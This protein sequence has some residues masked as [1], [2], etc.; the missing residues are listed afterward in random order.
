MPYG[1]TGHV[2]SGVI[3]GDIPNPGSA[4][5]AE[6][7]RVVPVGEA[8]PGND[9]IV[10]WRLTCKAVD[11]ASV[12]FRASSL[13]ACIGQ[14]VHAGKELMPKWANGA[15]LLVPLSLGQVEG[16]G[17]KLNAHHLVSR[18]REYRNIVRVLRNVRVRG[19]RSFKRPQITL[20]QGPLEGPSIG[21]EEQFAV[22]GEGGRDSRSACG[23]APCTLDGAGPR[24][25]E[26]GAPMSR[27]AEWLNGPLPTEGSFGVGADL[28]GSPLRSEPSLSGW[29]RNPLRTRTGPGIEVH[30]AFAKP[31]AL[32]LVQIEGIGAFFGLC[33]RRAGGKTLGLSFQ[34]RCGGLDG[35]TAL[36]VRDIAPG[37]A[38]DAWNQQCAGG[39]MDVKRIRPGDLILR[40]NDQGDVTRM[41][42]ECSRREL[43]KLLVVRGNFSRH[44]LIAVT[45]AVAQHV[46]ERDGNEAEL[47]PAAGTGEPG[48]ETQTPTHIHT[49]TPTHIHT[50][51]PTHIHTEA[52]TP[53]LPAAESDS[54]SVASGEDGDLLRA[55]A[56]S[57]IYY[58][59]SSE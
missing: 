46:R 47:I 1:S 50:Q 13:T 19:L 18:F 4:A 24:K 7:E 11:I 16:S 56:A 8:A 53:S 3:S 58:L 59:E 5:G 29:W 42:Y 37:S 48:T 34:Q 17:W 52:Q 25:A 57:T 12:V 32:P 54:S 22:S 26:T 10:L 33:I 14:V 6:P 45:A 43:V 15:I 9:Q 55:I 35:L 49:Q 41:L 51:T 20:E 23:A 38:V 39:P 44:L 2:D 40:A 28:G 30:Q 36:W 21:C 27:A 31:T